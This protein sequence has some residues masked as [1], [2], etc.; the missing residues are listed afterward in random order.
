M[1]GEASDNFLMGY[2]RFAH[3]AAAYIFVIGFVFRVYWAFVGNRPRAAA[4][5]AADLQ[6]RLVGRRLAR[7]QVVRVHDP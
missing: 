6:P 4:F 5:P 7:G 3:F 1:P 2:I